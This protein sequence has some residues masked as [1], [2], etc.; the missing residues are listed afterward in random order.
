MH[1][2]LRVAGHEAT[3]ITL[4]TSGFCASIDCL[5]RAIAIDAAFRQIDLAEKDLMQM[6]SAQ[7][8]APHTNASTESIKAIHI[9][10]E[11]LRG[12]AVAPEQPKPIISTITNTC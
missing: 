12:Y 1:D 10:K 5:G 3:H 6:D 7:A 11:Y 8:N 2:F 4:K 9:A